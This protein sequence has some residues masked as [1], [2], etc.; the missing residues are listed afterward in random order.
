MGGISQLK[1]V[2][3]QYITSYWCLAKK[4]QAKISPVFPSFNF[5]HIPAY[6]LVVLMFLLDFLISVIFNCSCS[7]W[8]F[9]SCSNFLVIFIRSCWI[10]QMIYPHLNRY[11]LMILIWCYCK[12]SNWLD[13][14][15]KYSKQNNI[16]LLKV[17]FQIQFITPA[18]TTAGHWANN[19]WAK[20]KTIFILWPRVI[21]PE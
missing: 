11:Y 6:R 2:I 13:M 5:G 20:I 3:D 12:S 10:D 8:S 1:Q 18:T 21:H 17:K 16:L 9:R 19:F 14:K 4:Y 15:V 7:M